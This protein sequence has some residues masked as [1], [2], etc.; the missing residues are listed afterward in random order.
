[1]PIYEYACEDCNETH[2]VLQRITDDPLEICPR[3]GGRLNKLISNTS[4]ILKG[5]GWYATDYG[6]G[7]N[8]G[9]GNGT[10]RA[11][12]STGGN[13]KA[14]LKGDGGTGKDIKD[15]SISESSGDKVSGKAKAPSED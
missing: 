7:G 9:K 2:E 3:C 10:K 15:A 1:M 11:G 13:G 5:T 6:S 12:S 8:G 14:N 4:F